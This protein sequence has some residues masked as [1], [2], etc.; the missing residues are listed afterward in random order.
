MTTEG[1]LLR[2]VQSGSLSEV[3]SALDAGVSPDAVIGEETLGFHSSFVGESAISK[4]CMGAPL[5]DDDDYH[6]DQGVTEGIV[7]ALLRVGANPNPDSRSPPLVYSTLSGNAPITKMLLDAGADAR[8]IPTPVGFGGPLHR[9]CSFSAA[10]VELLL[11]SGADSVVNVQ[12][13]WGMNGPFFYP[14]DLVVKGIV[15][16]PGPMP[17]IER[18]L[19]LLLRAGAIF[20][21]P[22]YSG[23]L[24][25]GDAG[26]PLLSYLDRV[27]TAGGF[28]RYEQRHI[29]AL[30]ATF[31]PKLG[32]P[33]E[34]AR[35]VVTFYAHC[36]F[37]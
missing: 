25:A 2:A 7:R 15:E 33:P 19:P 22:Y 14:L 30:A 36:G 37:Y 32:L 12:M 21:T 24:S 13:Q 28:R 20:P 23:L 5:P 1:D 27:L 3:V 17:Q 26:D 10:C 29:N 11:A 18:A 35:V 9:A 34:I 6:H 8:Y 4:A 16:D 31:G